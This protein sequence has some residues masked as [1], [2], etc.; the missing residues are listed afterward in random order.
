[1]AA[2]VGVLQL[3]I[4]DRSDMLTDRRKRTEDRRKLIES[5]AGRSPPAWVAALRH[6]NES[7]SARRSGGGFGQRRRC[8]NHSLEQGQRHRGADCAQEGAPWHRFLCNNHKL[9]LIVNGVLLTIPR[10]MEEKR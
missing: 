6:E 1:M 3:Q 4:R 9:F 2:G 5:V 10:M 8:G 7:E